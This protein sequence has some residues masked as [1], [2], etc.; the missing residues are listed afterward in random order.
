MSENLESE[1]TPL[2]E[3]SVSENPSFDAFEYDS[4][5][6]YLPEDL[7]ED[8]LNTGTLGENFTEEKSFEA[9]LKKSL[10]STELRKIHT[11]ARSGTLHRVKVRDAVDGETYTDGDGSGPSQ[12]ASQIGIEDVFL[13]D[14]IMVEP[15]SLANIRDM[16]A[17]MHRKKSVRLRVKE[18]EKKERPLSGW[19][20]FKLDRAM[21]WT[22]FKITI[23]DSISQYTIWKDH[24][25]EV[26]GLFGTGVLS[27]FTFLRW[28]LYINLIVSLLTLCFLFVP[29]M[30]FEQSASYLSSSRFSGLELLTGEGYF[31]QTEMFYGVYTNESINDRYN[32]KYAY[33]FVG[34]GYAII[35]IIVL[36]KS[37]ASSYNENFIMSGGEKVASFSSK[38]FCTW[39]F[40]ISNKE[41]ARIKMK[42]FAQDM[43]ETLG[44]S[45]KKF[46][47]DCC[48]IFLM[49][50]LRLLMNIV[51]VTLLLGSAFLIYY[52]SDMSVQESFESGHEEEHQ[53]KGL[54]PAMTM[55]GLNL[56]IPT[57]FRLI[58]SIE[59]YSNPRIELT[60]NM[61]R[62]VTLKLISL[63]VYTVTV[64]VKLSNVESETRLSRC[65]ENFFGQAFYKLAIVDFLAVLLATFFGEFIRRLIAERCCKRHMPG[66]DISKNVLNLIYSQ[67]IC[68]LGTFYCPLL[69]FVN[70]LKLIIIFYVKKVSITRNCRPSTRPFKASKMLLW[71][72]CL[73]SL[74][75]VLALV[76]VGYIIMDETTLKPSL[77]CGPFRGQERIYDIVSDIIQETPRIVRNA[78]EILSSISV[79]AAF[80]FMMGLLAYYFR[81]R[82]VSNEKKIKLLKQQLSLAGQD[83]KYLIEKLKFVMSA[84]HID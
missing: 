37:M 41:T 75:L 26:E 55:S 11:L 59:N 20:K 38:V 48:S 67:G 76:V 30:I 6:Q 39:D 70:V 16:T 32:M 65:W 42:S 12:G 9:G 18:K 79:I 22:K 74:M 34:S 81:M 63:V 64:I 58:A 24:M 61:L 35:C 40:G 2:R 83:R 15:A 21:G 44:S 80:L 1:R 47:M 3:R 7:E 72:L 78:V 53:I 19:K 23:K 49:V 4:F 28:L 50:M 62:T 8:F 51:T 69:P 10:P 27:Y 71:F 66:F 31:N 29:Q 25:K 77:Y 60:I 46:K 82:K 5:A 13:E 54:L 57:G 73:L 84:D 45:R 43:L 17:T 68:W 56:I 36:A 52:V 14:N 33:L